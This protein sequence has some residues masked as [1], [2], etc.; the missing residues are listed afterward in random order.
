MASLEGMPSTRVTLWQSPRA[1]VN[2]NRFSCAGAPPPRNGYLS[3]ISDEFGGYC[4]SLVEEAWPNVDT[5][6]MSQRKMKPT[7]LASTL[8]LQIICLAITVGLVL[9]VNKIVDVQITMTKAP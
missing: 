2:H 5:S 7:I 9:T 4:N 6:K 1:A 8:A 3:S